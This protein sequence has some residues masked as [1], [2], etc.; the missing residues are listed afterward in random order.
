[1]VP[2][3]TVIAVLAVGVVGYLVLKNGSP[4]TK[5][6]SATT[7]TLATPATPG[8]PAGGPVTAHPLPPTATLTGDELLVVSV[9]VVRDP[10][11]KGTNLAAAI[12]H[13]NIQA[14]QDIVGTTP[15]DALL[16]SEVAGTV[17]P[18]DLAPGTILTRSLVNAASTGRPTTTTPAGSACPADP[19]APPAG[20]VLGF[21]AVGTIPRGMSAAAAFA[22]NLLAPVAV[23]RAYAFPTQITSVAAICTLAA[24]HDLEPSTVIVP[25]LFA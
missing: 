11:T 9:L 7:T 8:A 4:A 17:A 2:V 19:P 22:G 24:N 21:R 1:L 3:V 23:P 15:K 18:F 25:G 16:D 6:A 14:T 10:I 20:T 5:T 13:A 12:D